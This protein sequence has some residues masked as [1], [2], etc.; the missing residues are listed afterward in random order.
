M[1]NINLLCQNK[2]PE[3][4][5]CDRKISEKIISEE[6]VELLISDILGILPRATS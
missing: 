3:A 5:L 1:E 2:V 6:A 4:R